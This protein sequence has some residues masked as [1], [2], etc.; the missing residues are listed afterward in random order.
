MRHYHRLTKRALQGSNAHMSIAFKTAERF[1]DHAW[2]MA[3]G[4]RDSLRTDQF[5]VRDL[6]YADGQG[7]DFPRQ[8]T[9][10][11]RLV[12][13][14]VITHKCKCAWQGRSGSSKGSDREDECTQ[15]GYDG[16]EGHK[17][18]LALVP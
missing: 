18:L 12:A 14:I 15:E 17:A 2:C 8:S 1:S 7:T 3:A 16:K 4:I 6:R 5:Y 13:T 11:S 10:L 9:F